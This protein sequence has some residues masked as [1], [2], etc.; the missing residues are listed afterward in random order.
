[1]TVPS[2]PHVKASS[3]SRFRGFA[4]ATLACC[5]LEKLCTNSQPQVAAHQKFSVTFP[6]KASGIPGPVSRLISCKLGSLFQGYRGAAVIRRLVH[7]I[8]SGHQ[9]FR[10]P[11]A[12]I[13]RYRPPV[14]ARPASFPEGPEHHA[15]G[16]GTPQRRTVSSTVCDHRI[17]GNPPDDGVDRARLEL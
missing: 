17:E 16:R 6:S 9:S 2:K 4:L 10:H 13:R 14:D 8:G 11:L 1:V 7:C 15:D 5:R 12:D 3:G